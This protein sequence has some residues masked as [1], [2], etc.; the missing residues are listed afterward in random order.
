MS[1]PFHEL[2]SATVDHL[3]HLKK[4]GAR[5]VQVSTATLQSLAKP[6]GRAFTQI[7]ETKPLTGITPVD[8]K[9]LLL[10]EI[11]DR[12]FACLKC[13]HLASSRKTVVFGVGDPNATL[14]FVGEAPGA[15]E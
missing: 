4:Q 1:E 11:P 6:P 12:A 2:L 10:H 13:S 7:Q 5:H 15:D 8:P 3:S 9:A 14:M